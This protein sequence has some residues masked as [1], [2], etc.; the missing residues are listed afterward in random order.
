M[1]RLIHEV[2]SSKRPTSKFQR[3]SKMKAPKALGACEPELDLGAS[4]VLGSW[5]LGTFHYVLQQVSK[6]LFTL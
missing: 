1:P 4:L 2:K 6:R 5:T 3:N